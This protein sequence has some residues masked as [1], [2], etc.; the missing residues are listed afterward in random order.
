M[1]T[2][3]LHTIVIKT[4]FILTKSNS[5]RDSNL[6]IGAVFSSDFSLK[7][8]MSVQGSLVVSKSNALLND[9]N[10]RTTHFCFYTNLRIAEEVVDSETFE[11]NFI[12]S[13][14]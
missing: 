12:I 6:A 14:Q 10:L 7:D 8:A 3:L 1:G 9:A 5:S 2:N 13:C 11:A 4:F